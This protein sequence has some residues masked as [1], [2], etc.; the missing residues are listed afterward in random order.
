M[1]NFIRK[2]IKQNTNEPIVF[3]AIEWIDTNEEDFEALEG[4]EGSGGDSEGDPDLDSDSDPTEEKYTIRVFGV[5]Q[6]G[7]SVCLTIKNYTPFF[8]V[9]VPQFFNG[10]HLEKMLSYLNFMLKFKYPG[11]LVKKYCRIETKMDYYGFQNEIK[12]KFARLVFTNSDAMKFASYIFNKPVRINTISATKDYFYQKYESNI[13]QIIRFIHSRKLLSTGWLRV[14]GGKYTNSD[15]SSCQID[16]QT[17]WFNVNL[18]ESLGDQIAPFLQASF[19]IECFSHDG[20]LPMPDHPKNSVITIATAFKVYGSSKFL[21]KHVITLKKSNELQ[22]DREECPVILE[23]YNTE[24][25]VLLA[26]R[27]LIK[28]TDP[29]ILYTYNGD[30][31]DCNYLI[32]RSKRTR[33]FQKFSELS[34]L[35]MHKCD[36]KETSFSSGAYGHSDY[37]KLPIPGRVNFDIIIYIRRE[38]KLESYKLDSVAEKFLGEKKDPVTPRMIFEY[39]NSGDPEKIRIVTEYCVQDTLLPQRLVD[40]LDILPILIEMAKLTY[41]PFRYLFERGQGIKVISQ[42]VKSTK[43]KGYLIPHISYKNDSSGKFQGATVLDPIVGFYDTPVSTLDFA[44]LYP[45]IMMAHNFC[46]SS[47]VLKEKYS[48]VPGVEYFT[49][50]WDS[51]SYKFAQNN[52]SILPALLKDLYSSRKYVKKLMKNEKDPFKKSVLNGRQLAIKV[53]MNSVYGFLAAPMLECK[54]IAACVTT[55]GRQMIEKSK[56]YAEKDFTKF[57]NETGLAK[58]LKTTVVYGDTDSIFCQFKTDTEGDAAMEESFKLADICATMITR[59]LFKEPIVLEFEKVYGVL[60]M[61]GKKM[62]I[63]SLYESSPFKMDKIDIKGVALKRRDNCHLLKKIYTEVIDVMLEKKR[64]GINDAIKIVKRYLSDLDNNRID[65]KDLIISKSLRFD[66][67][68]PNIP[69]KVLAEKIAKRDPGAAPKSGDRVPYI[70]IDTGNPKHKQFE[71]VED[72]E[73]AKE[74]GLKVDTIYYIEKQIKNPISQFFSLLMDNPDEL[75]KDAIRSAKNKKSKQME[76]S[77]FFKK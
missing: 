2:K 66:Y 44:S 39:F 13:D 56:N 49:C 20:A 17:N 28:D 54:P 52:T 16:V 47:I 61:L 29:D 62:Y 69:H 55:V 75:F 8:Y 5:T 31:F 27:R 6:E 32:V 60:F 77:S 70:F 45:S 51:Y 63:G 59:D 9:K 37:K 19:D 76:I 53:S 4:L 64:Q 3:Q 24:K 72:P 73:Y 57:A 43:E 65:F 46:Y 67:K 50:E 15:F 34:R 74:K 11:T 58:N 35:R 26:W 23:C 30:Q 36:I 25:E 14:E 38:I 33:C 12:F 42:I 22:L 10:S 21:L 48:N 7:F 41:V 71:K 1:D 18:E 68:S 40:K